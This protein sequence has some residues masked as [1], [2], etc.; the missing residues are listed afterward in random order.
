MILRARCT[1]N[2][3]KIGKTSKKTWLGHI[4]RGHI[5][6]H[7]EKEPNFHQK[8]QFMA[9]NLFFLDSSWRRGVANVLSGKTFM[10]TEHHS[11]RAPQQLP[12]DLLLAKHVL[13][14]R[15]GHVPPLAAAFDGPYL[16][17]ERSLRYFKLQVSDRPNIFS[18]LKLKPCR[19]PL[20]EQ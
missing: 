15:D 10:P 3:S 18:T 11:T 20:E 7:R 19:S 4:H 6:L 12:E 13:V 1:K 14:R 5:N 17:L 2:S 8:K 9:H 16:V